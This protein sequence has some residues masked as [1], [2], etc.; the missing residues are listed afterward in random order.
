MP[1]GIGLPGKMSKP[2]PKWIMKK[3]SMLWAK[4]GNGEF[5]HSTAFEELKRDRMTSIALSELRKSG[6]LDIKLDPSDARK[7]LYRLKS[8]EAAV[9]EMAKDSG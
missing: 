4:F 2:L 6:W 5:N 3:Y 8:P 1:I 7:R 9:R